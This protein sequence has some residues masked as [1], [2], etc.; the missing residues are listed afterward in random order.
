MTLLVSRKT[1]TK[2]R[3]IT[4]IIVVFEIEFINISFCLKVYISTS[5][6]LK[7]LISV[8]ISPIYSHFGE[9]LNGLSTIRAFELQSKFT[10]HSEKLVDTYTSC[11]FSSFIV[12]MW[13]QVRL[14]VLGNLIVFAAALFTII[15]KDSINP[16]MV[17]L[18]IT[19]A[20]VMTQGYTS[21]HSHFIKVKI[22]H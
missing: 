1:V 3:V 19:Y 7:R 21:Q 14:E 8:T 10:S 17:G 13:L 9:T 18:I 4:S 22:S 11:T 5:R 2:S 16:S 15:W 20:S 6:Q 12:R